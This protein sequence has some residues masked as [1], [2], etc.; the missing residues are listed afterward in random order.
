MG[1][2]IEPIKHI[3]YKSGRLKEFWKGNV[4]VIGLASSFIEPLEATSIHATGLQIYLFCQE[5]LSSTKEKTLN[6]ASIQ[7]Y[8]AKT[9]KMYEYYKDF[10]VFH[11]QGGRE[12]SEFWRTIKFD[13][14][15]SP[16]VE[17]YIERSKSRIPTVLHFMDFWR[18][19]GLWRWTLAGLGYVTKQQALDELVQFKQLKY[20]QLDYQKFRDGMMEFLA[21]QPPFE[22]EVKKEQ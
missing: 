2:P 4:I 13:K 15:I 6:Q 21:E 11:Y 19:D 3:N 1:H 5:Y 10:T 8:N 17:N 9:A 14:V 12:D 20:A 22:I 16:A 18:L 7:K